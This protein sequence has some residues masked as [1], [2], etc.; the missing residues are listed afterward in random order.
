MEMRVYLKEFSH[1]V[2]NLSSLL[3]KISSQSSDHFS[4]ASKSH[5]ISKFPQLTKTILNTT[6]TTVITF[7]QTFSK[8][9]KPLFSHHIH[10]IIIQLWRFRPQIL[11]TEQL[12][13]TA[14]S[15]TTIMI[16]CTIIFNHNR[17]SLFL[18][19]VLTS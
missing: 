16:T 14:W 5:Y 19:T 10:H 15:I 3:P 2:L 17:P 1:Y 18:S 9:H 6:V 13:I 7:K 8:H 4:P 11:V 12:F